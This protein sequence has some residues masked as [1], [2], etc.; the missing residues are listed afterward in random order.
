ME[1]LLKAEDLK[2]SFKQGETEFSAVKG[3]SFFIRP[4]Q[5]YSLV[6]ETGSGK[7]VTALSLCGL[8]GGDSRVQGR[9]LFDTGKG[10]VNVLERNNF[11]NLRGRYINYIFQDPLSSLDPLM[12]VGCQIAEGLLWHKKIP[13]K[14]AFDQAKQKL[15]EVLI[16]DVERV[17]FSFPHQLS[18]GQAQRVMIAQALALES[19]LLIAD[20]PTSSLD[21]TVE[22]EIIRLLKRLSQRKNLAILFITHDLTLVK[23]LS[24]RAG[25]LQGGRIIEEFSA[26]DIFS[27]GHKPYTQK[28]IDSCM[29]L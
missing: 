27:A 20:E 14:S 5:I 26:R 6:G 13:A 16:D 11:L 1:F 28:L 10:V 21:V 18:G 7:T 25:V 8:L 17:F 4:G 9:I 29:I 3:I 23:Y 15:R 2:I 12:R 24:G 22:M 19:K